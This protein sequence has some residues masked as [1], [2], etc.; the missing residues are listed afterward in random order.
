MSIKHNIHQS[1]YLSGKIY[2]MYHQIKKPIVLFDLYHTIVD[3][4]ID[5]DFREFWQVIESHLNQYGNKLGPDDLRDL[6]RELDR[7]IKL[8]TLKGQTILETL[9]PRYFR[10]VTGQPANLGQL[11]NFI[12]IFRRASRKTL[13]VRKFLPPLLSKLNK[14]GY[15]YGIVSNTE[16]VFTKI[17][18]E[19]LHISDKFKC[20]VLSSDVGAEKPD[21]K[22]FLTALS[23]MKSSAGDAIFIGD[24]FEADII[25]AD[26]VGMRSIL[27]SDN[28]DEF[29]D[30]LPEKCLGIIPSSGKG[31]YRK[32]ISS[33]E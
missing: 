1:A 18:L 16:A 21:P 3:I 23:T 29:K 13:L 28:P 20:I 19:D 24:N 5:E 8:D 31:L 15:S 22:P 10:I 27:I 11:Y 12:T 2:H 32:I 14:Q 4:E 26:K 33:H 17:D 9:F 6:Y 30:R 25:G 7:Q